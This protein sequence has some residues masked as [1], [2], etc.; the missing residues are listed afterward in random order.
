MLL[1]D[2]R[3]LRCWRADSTINFFEI[4]FPSKNS[5]VAANRAVALSCFASSE[6]EGRECLVITDLLQPKGH[7][8]WQ[9][10]FSSDDAVAGGS[11]AAGTLSRAW[12]QSRLRYH[13]EN[14][15]P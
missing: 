7:L 14:N 2:F 10:P 5:N 11:C 6:K 9:F 4:L 13:P 1:S 3:R 8:R 15:K 12:I